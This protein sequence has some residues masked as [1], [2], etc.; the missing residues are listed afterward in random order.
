MELP[1]TAEQFFAVF[2]DYNRAF[3]FVVIALWLTTAAVLALVWRSPARHSRMLSLWLGALWLW[4]A[5][6]YHA[7]SFTRINPAAWLFAALFAA[8]SLLLIRAGVRNDVEYFS[9]SRALGAGLV[10][11]ALVYPLLRVGLAHGY[12]AA[13]TFGVPCP[14]AILTFGLLLTAREA[15]PVSI[16]VVPALWGFVGGS[17]R[18]PE[19]AYRLCTARRRRV[20]HA[21]RVDAR[22][23]A[24]WGLSALARNHAG[25]LVA[26]HDHP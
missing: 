9:S 13:P 6:A 18:P 4:N 14:T 22:N 2:A 3:G 11:Y 17:R 20:S 12:P 10:V 24:G 26:A 7:L 5:A 16:G 23:C 25:A 8:E 21:H 19:C 1:F 15:V